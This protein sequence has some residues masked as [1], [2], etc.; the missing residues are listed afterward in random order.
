MADRL[1]HVDATAGVAGDMLLGA[2][3]DAGA[4]LATVRT[5]IAS[6]G[7]GAAV[8][9]A[10]ARRGG[11]ACARLRVDLPARP[12][13]ERRLDDVLA[14]VGAA[15]LEPAAAR[16][17]AGVF[18]RLARAEGAVH[19]LPPEAVHFHEVGALD[20]LVDVVGTAAAAGSLGLLDAGAGTTCSPLAA[21]SGTVRSAHGVLP[22]PAPAVL[23]LVAD[24]GLELTGGDLGGERT[25]PTGAALVAEL[26][27]PGPLP[28]LR[29]EA[30]GVGGGSR[31]PDDRP[32]VTRVVLGR[33][34]S[35]TTGRRADQALVVEAT[36]DDLD[37][38]VWPSVL[39][40]VRASGAWDCW[41]TPVIGRHGRPAQVLSVLCAPGVR[42]AV[43]DAVFRHTS[44]FG[45][46]WSGWERATARRRSVPVEVG[47]AG[48]RQVVTVKVA[49]AVDDVP[50][51]ATPELAEAEA[52]AVALDWPVRAV[53]E[54]ALVAYRTREGLTPS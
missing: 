18:R 32:N 4:N 41:T 45:V 49:E 43:V 2:L 27:V 54:A 38:R 39:A 12:D 7:V 50:V 42:E 24:A 36:V 3:L 46:R 8:D 25:T 26:A 10:R 34:A 6:L 17:A 22:V 5:A 9:V 40:A 33:A 30:V 13:R 35:T 21:G 11:L 20:A 14:L 28:A 51:L 31:D 1:A 47:P 48:A 44:T 15:D 53:C 19:D 23:R 37:P 29:V 16:L 52:A